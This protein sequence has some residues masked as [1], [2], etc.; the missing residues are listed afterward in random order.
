MA[1]NLVSIRAIC[2][3]LGVAISCLAGNPD[4]EGNG[5]QKSFKLHITRL[6]YLANENF[7][8]IEV[9]AN[10]IPAHLTFTSAKERAVI[11]SVVG[12]PIYVSIWDKSIYFRV[13]CESTKMPEEEQK[14][15]GYEPA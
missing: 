1:D 15:Q 11:G 6:L 9:P 5:Q 8:F 12:Y 13:R 10:T 4:S 2:E 3:N 7:L 14:E